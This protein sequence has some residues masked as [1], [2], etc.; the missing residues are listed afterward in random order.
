M[1]IEYIPNPSSENID[2][3]KDQLNK[4]AAGFKSVDTFV[5]FIKDADK[6]IQAGLDG[7]FMYGAI[8]TDQLWVAPGY[9][10]LGLGR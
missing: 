4:A 10:R 7:F 8:C 6:Q 3:L 9:R 2:F 1:N 5:F